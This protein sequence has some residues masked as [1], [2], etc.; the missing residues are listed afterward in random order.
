MNKISIIF[1]GKL[2]AG[3]FKFNRTGKDALTGNVGLYA[4]VNFTRYGLRKGCNAN[5]ITAPIM[6]TIML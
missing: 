4:W 6:A 5:P 2:M 3:R 1:T